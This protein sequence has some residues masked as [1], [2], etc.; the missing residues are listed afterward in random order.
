VK[1][2]L[3]CKA[4]NKIINTIDYNSDDIRKWS[5]KGIL[6]CPVCESKVGLRNG[7]VRIPHFYHIEKDGC[8]LGYW[9]NESKTHYLGKILLYKWLK[10]LTS[11]E[12][13]NIEYWIKETKQRPD[14]YFEQNERKYVIEFQCSNLTL[15]RYFERRKLYELLDI[16]DI[17]IF[18][19]DFNFK[20]FKAV[21]K[22]FMQSHG[23]TY[24]LKP[25]KKQ[26]YTVLKDSRDTY[27]QDM[28]N[29]NN[30]YIE[31]GLI[32]SEFEIELGFKGSMRKI[33]KSSKVFNEKEVDN[34]FL[35]K[36][37]AGL[38]KDTYISSSYEMEQIIKNRKKKHGY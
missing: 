8:D 6:K 35:E 27:T 25:F 2:V 4:G 33:N 32:F 24:Y 30:F 11:I 28:E 37:N 21:D 9:E 38:I 17:W 22:F 23:R 13:L 5:D 14:I 36:I 15:E 18:G 10:Q 19:T 31:D 7:M 3:S 16:H 1:Q 34:Y 26:L 20:K 29:Y 12:N